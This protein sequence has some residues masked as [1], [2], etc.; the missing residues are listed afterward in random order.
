MSNFCFLETVDTL[1]D[2]SFHPSVEVIS[3]INSLFFVLIEKEQN[4]KKTKKNF[5][6]TTHKTNKNFKSL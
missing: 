5:A 4:V 6:K 3:K 2:I 1:G